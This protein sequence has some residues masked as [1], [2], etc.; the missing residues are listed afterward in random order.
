MQNL[1]QKETMPHKYQESIHYKTIIEGLG[2]FQN[3]AQ[4]M[5]LRIDNCIAQ[6]ICNKRI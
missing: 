4:I 1:I 6:N 3:V 5:K 2:Q